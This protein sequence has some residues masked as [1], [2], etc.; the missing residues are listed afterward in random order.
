MYR[1]DFYQ[2]PV[3][4]GVRLSLDKLRCDAARMGM[5]RFNVTLPSGRRYQKCSRLVS[6]QGDT[7]KTRLETGSD[8]DEQALRILFDYID[9][10]GCGKIA[11]DD[12]IAA[13]CSNPAMVMQ[14]SRNGGNQDGPAEVTNAQASE[15]LGESFA[16]KFWRHE[17][18]WIQEFL[19]E[20][21][22]DGC[23]T[24]EWPHFLD[25]FRRA[26]LYVQSWTCQE[27]LV[28]KAEGSE[29]GGD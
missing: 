21:D 17:A 11:R 8:F 2:I 16:N 10:D 12:L 27:Q 9:K 14:F 3:Q 20:A 1:G 23:G 19:Q 22:V 25:F 24:L 5:A 7:E 13:L 28:G 26:Q 6:D 18:H 4:Q 29:D 15:G